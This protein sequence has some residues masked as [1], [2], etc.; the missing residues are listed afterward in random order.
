MKI[1]QMSIAGAVLIVVVILIRALA[2]HRLPKKTFLFL[3]ALVLLRLLLPFS[4]PSP[5]SF[6]SLPA[7]RAVQSPMVAVPAPQ[8]ALSAPEAARGEAQNTAASPHRSSLPPLLVVWLIGGLACTAYFAVAY[9]RSRRVFREALPVENPRLNALLAGYRTIRPVQLRQSDRISAPLTYGVFRPVILVPKGLDWGNTAQ[10][11]YILAHEFIHIQRFDAAAKLLLTAALC[12]HWFNPLVWLMYI[13]ANRDMELSCDETVVRYFGENARGDYARTLIQMEEEK[14]GFPP[15]CNNFSKNAIEE[16]I[17]AIMKTKKRSVLAVFTALVLV[18]GVAVVFASSAAAAPRVASPSRPSASFSEAEY[19]KLLAL[20]FEAYEKMTVAEYREKVWQRIDTEEMMALLERVSQDTTLLEKKNS[21]E[22]AFFFLN[23]LV[24]LVAER[25]ESRDFNGYV[26]GQLDVSELPLVEYSFVLT[27]RDANALTVGQYIGAQNAVAEGM[28]AMLN[29]RTAEELQDE[30]ALDEAAEAE[31]KRLQ[32]KWNSAALELEILAECKPMMKLDDA[33]LRQIT[34]E[35]D[36]DLEPYLAFGISYELNEWDGQAKLF[37]NGRQ[38]RGIYDAINGWVT[39]SAGNT[40]F[41]ADMPELVAVYEGETLTGLREATGEE[42]QEF[43][44]IRSTN[45]ENLM[46]EP[47]HATAADF[48]S[49]LALKTPGY[50]EMTVAVFNDALID[51][52]NEDYERNER[53]NQ[54]IAQQNYVVSLTGE[55][56]AFLLSVYASGQ[57]NAALVRSLQTGKPREDAGFSQNYYKTEPDGSFCTLYLQVSYHIADEKK[58]TIAERDRCVLGIA[59]D[60]TQ[61][62]HNSSL[63]NLLSMS[64]D[65]MKARLKALA[66]ARSSGQITVQIATELP[67]YHFEQMDETSRRPVEGNGTSI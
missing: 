11:D 48:D 28:Q 58:L 33:S 46:E 50:G 22:T 63:Q 15:L 55:E 62:W 38:V 27:I 31:I 20:R 61:F 37:W 24:P 44:E 40:S 41:T 45:S 49:L 1:L 47:P 66:E 32:D 51:W 39:N 5:V 64:Q 25:W 65:E 30:N 21:D 6:Y 26:S 36:R 59:D 43:D 10:I 7:V 8:P 13:L 12:L 2:M 3:W 29:A 42:Q 14:S 67:Q 60:I 23:V 52:A 17:R 34:M 16:R 56:R 54:D 57:E 18:A 9:G 35:W 4:I 53:I 19:E